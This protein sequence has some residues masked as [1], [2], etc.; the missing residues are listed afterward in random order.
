MDCDVIVDLVGKAFLYLCLER[1][2]LLLSRA[3]GSLR[4]FSVLVLSSILSAII[5]MRMLMLM[6]C[7]LVSLPN[8]NSLMLEAFVHVCMTFSL[9]S[10]IQQ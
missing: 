2:S 3:C 5:M 9:W 10:A 7:K 8:G 1:G 6:N 4:S